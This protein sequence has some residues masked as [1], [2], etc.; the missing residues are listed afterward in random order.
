MHYLSP[1]KMKGVAVVIC[2][3]QRVA[4]DYVC[5]NVS[6]VLGDVHKLKSKSIM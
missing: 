4:F 1:S 5:T 2:F 6:S 3:Y